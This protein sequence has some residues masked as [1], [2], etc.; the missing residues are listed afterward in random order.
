[1]TRIVSSRMTR[2]VQYEMKVALI[3]LKLELNSTK[4]IIQMRKC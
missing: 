1:M 3:M 2:R 4:N